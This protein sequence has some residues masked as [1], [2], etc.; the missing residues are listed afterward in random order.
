MRSDISASPSTVFDLTAR[1]TLPQGIPP[2]G[3]P[4]PSEPPPAV[5]VPADPNVTE[6][7]GGLGAI[8]EFHWQLA[9]AGDVTVEQ[10]HAFR[11]TGMIPPS[12]SSSS[13]SLY[14][15]MT[16][17]GSGSES[18]RWGPTS[19]GAPGLECGGSQTIYVTVESDTFMVAVIT[20]AGAPVELTYSLQI[21]VGNPY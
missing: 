5:T 15:V 12:P 21:N 10:Q 2:A 1:S 20:L 7:E 6:I 8:Y 9:A 4:I 14:L 11:V 19:L 17:E 18:F 16:C 13:R 3:T